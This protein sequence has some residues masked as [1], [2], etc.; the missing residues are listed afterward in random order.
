VATPGV[1]DWR[2]RWIWAKL[3]LVGLLTGFHLLLAAWRREFAAGSFTRPARFYR[4][5]NEIP[6]VIMIAIVLL[7]VLKP[8]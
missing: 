7:V 6:T 4:V 1:I 2:D 8:F 3:A 5:I